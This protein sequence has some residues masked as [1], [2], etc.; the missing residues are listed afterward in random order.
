MI[1]FS[2]LKRI[3]SWDVQVYDDLAGRSRLLQYSTL[4]LVL[5][6]LFYGVTAV[7]FSRSLLSLRGVDAGADFNVLFLI[8]MGIAVSFLMHGAAALFIWVFCRGIGG[9]SLFMPLY[10]SSGVAAAAAWPLAPVVAAIQAGHTSAAMTVL[11]LVLA[12]YLFTVGFVAV[13]KATG[14]NKLRMSIAAVATFIYMGCFLYL[15]L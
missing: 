4:H 15:W 5:L 13:R 14:L 10:L 8:L 7:A 2:D 6:G 1:Y 12:A 11:A 9:S 3:L